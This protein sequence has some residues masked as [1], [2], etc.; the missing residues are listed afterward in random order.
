M[1]RQTPVLDPQPS[2]PRRAH[3]AVG[4]VWVAV[5][6]AGSVAIGLVGLAAA[7]GVTRIGRS[8]YDTEFIHPATSGA[9]L[10]LLLPAMMAGR[11]AGRLV[12]PVVLA[13]AVPQWLV[14]GEV[15]GRYQE[16]GWGDGLE[17]FAYLTPLW[18]GFLCA[19]AAS[20]GWLLGRNRREIRPRPQPG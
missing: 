10:L 20:L 16:S 18:V 3:L 9:L 14:A 19:V 1:T 2:A 17:V 15:V 4:L 11:S 12:V 5:T 7:R 6:L 8:S 13:A